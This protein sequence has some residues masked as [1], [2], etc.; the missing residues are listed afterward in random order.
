MPLTKC[1]DCEA[2]VSDSADFCPSCGAS[3]PSRSSLSKEPR[4]RL[5]TFDVALGVFFG[6]VAFALVSYVV[7]RAVLEGAL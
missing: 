3:R 5:S 4:P 7:W 6:Q 1:R 2:E